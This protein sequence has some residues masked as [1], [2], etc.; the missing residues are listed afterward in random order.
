MLNIKSRMSVGSI[1]SVKATRTSGTRGYDA[2]KKI[3][4]IKRHI[5]VDTL[6][7]V[8]VMVV[9]A[10]A[11]RVLDFQRQGHDVRLPSPSCGP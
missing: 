6:G 9:H 4:G 11:G 10:G 2:G 5:L 8:L 3:N 7:L 1:Q